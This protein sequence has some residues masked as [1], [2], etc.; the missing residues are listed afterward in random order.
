MSIMRWSRW[1]KSSHSNGTEQ[2]SCV[3]VGVAPGLVGI[4]DTKEGPNGRIIAVP[5]AA[6]RALV[7]RVSE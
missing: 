1:R 7:A 4:R 3:E 6:F 2:G 5:R